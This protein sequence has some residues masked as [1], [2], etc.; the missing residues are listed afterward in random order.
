MELKVGDKVVLKKELTLGERK[1]IPYFYI[2]MEHLLGQTFELLDISTYGNYGIN[3][4]V[5]GRWYINPQ[6]IDWEE[7]NKLNKIK[8]VI[9]EDRIVEC[10]EYKVEWNWGN[11]YLNENDKSRLAIRDKNGVIISLGFTK[12][13]YKQQMEITNLILDKLGLNVELVEGCDSNSE[14]LEQIGRLEA[15]LEK[16]RGM[17]K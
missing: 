3:S 8:M 7:T 11:S 6:W 4:E 5:D 17:I 1:L 12:L 15:E 16:L 14:V 10:G 9:G 2:E 13:N